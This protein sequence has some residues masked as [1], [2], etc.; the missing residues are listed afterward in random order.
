MA[1]LLASQLVAA[2]TLSYQQC[3]VLQ[4][5][6]ATAAALQSLSTSLGAK[7]LP[8]EEPVAGGEDGLQLNEQLVDRV[9]NGWVHVADDFRSLVGAKRLGASTV[10]L[11]EEAAETVGNVEE[12]GW[13]GAAIVEDFADAVCG[14]L[15]A[16]PDAVVAARRAAAARE[17]GDAETGEAMEILERRLRR[18]RAAAEWGARAGDVDAGLADGASSEAAAADAS[19]GQPLPAPDQPQAAHKFCIDCGARL[20]RRAKFCSECGGAQS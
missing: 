16:L 8:I 13:M 10:W 15:A 6:E 3:G 4:R 20:P 18:E 14:S 1:L 2:F 12:G 11:N 5:S 9:S 19:R 7:L 17:A